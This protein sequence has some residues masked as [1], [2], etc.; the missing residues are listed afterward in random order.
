MLRDWILFEIFLIKGAIFY[1]NSDRVNRY[2]IDNQTLD[3]EQN[4]TKAMAHIIE[5]KRRLNSHDSGEKFKIFMDKLTLLEGLVSLK[6]KGLSR[7][8]TEDTFSREMDKHSL[9][10]LRLTNSVIDICRDEFVNYS[11]TKEELIEDLKEVSKDFKEKNLKILEV[12]ANN[13]MA[14]LFLQSYMMN[15]RTFE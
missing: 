15:Q 6:S 14:E 4:L 12:K 13:C 7:S 10:D 9:G 5:G 3:V 11:K 1:E 8:A 2:D